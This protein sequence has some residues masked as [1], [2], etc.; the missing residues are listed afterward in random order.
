[1]SR[2]RSL[3]LLTAALGGLALAGCFRDEPPPLGCEAA[4][5]GPVTTGTSTTGIPEDPSSSSS[6]G[7]PGTTGEPPPGRAFRIDS[8]TIVEPHFFIPPGCADGT[9]LFNLALGGRITE[10]EFNMVVWFD[11]LDP[12]KLTLELTEA[13]SC[14]LEAM[15]CTRK[16]GQV[17]LKIPV[18]QVSSP[19]CSQ[20]DP[21][22]VSKINQPK[23][24][25]P[26]PL[27]QRTS[28][29][30]LALPIEDAAIP[31][32]MREAQVVFAFDAVDDP[33]LM[34]SGLI[35]GFLTQKSAEETTIDIGMDEPV[36]L[37]P[38]IDAIDCVD[39][40]P[41]YLPSVDTLV[42]NDQVLKGVWLA[43]NFTATRIELLDPP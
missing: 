9:D 31:V 24:H 25:A 6:T 23:L 2:P 4:G 35:Y 10:G 20:L 12:E 40:A 30:E 34:Q 17:S 1:M 42:D 28:P 38:M 3:L 29:A 22:V 14:D 26:E 41:D 33:Q 18:A 11:E 36:A 43:A 27:C 13:Q 19:P 32:N 7:A 8:L 5:C 39:V 37:W 16:P 21:A 15:T